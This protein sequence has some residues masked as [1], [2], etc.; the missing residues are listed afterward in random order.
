MSEG[1]EQRLEAF[2]AL[3][4]H[5]EEADDAID[6]ASP[7]EALPHSDPEMSPLAT[8]PRLAIVVG[9]TRI[10][11]GAV[12][13]PP[14]NMSEYPWNKDLAQRIAAICQASGIA[15]RTFFRDG[16]GIAGA[17]A[18]V[19]DWRA[20]AV[21]ELHFNA[22]GGAGHGTETLYGLVPRAE[23]FARVMQR[24][25]LD[26]LGLRDRGILL[27]R[28]GERGGES[29]NAPRMPG[30][31]IE[32]FFGDNRADAERGAE[33]KDALAQAVVAA[34]QRFVAVPVG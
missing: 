29:V 9:H 1:D 22:S 5:Q 28:P 8:G 10:A 17:Y 18:Q 3:R 15:S 32:P 4:A 23:A 34:F 27:R 7:R 20:D 25:M 24:S 31:L 11:A 16:I 6:R 14:I 21:C 19:N 12:A 13:G 2:E 30:V 26:A 33:R